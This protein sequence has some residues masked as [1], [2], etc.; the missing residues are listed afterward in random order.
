MTRDELLDKIEDIQYWQENFAGVF[1]VKAI[2]EVVD[3]HKPSPVPEWVPTES[4][5]I[6]WCAHKYP[7]P[8]IQIIEKG[9]G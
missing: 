3:L 2:R 8:T 9:L 5:E 4:E 6:C 1:F 7:C